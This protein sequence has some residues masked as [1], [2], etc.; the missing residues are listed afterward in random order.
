MP[1]ASSS[2]KSAQA[3]NV[4]PFPTNTIVAAPY[5]V[6]SD[7]EGYSTFQVVDYDDSEGVFYLRDPHDKEQPIITLPGSFLM[8]LS[9][10]IDVEVGDLVMAQ[11]YLE[12]EKVYTTALY[13]GICKSF[14]SETTARVEFFPTHE[15]ESTTEKQE[16][17]FNRMIACPTANILFLKRA[18]RLEY[19]E[20]EI[21]MDTILMDTIVNRG[22]E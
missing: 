20:Y 18:K 8:P 15:H 3:S 7:I 4:Q 17:P 14:P 9:W 12:D 11:Y 5:F 19:A 13:R 6:G 22:S 16:V 2:K 10:E 1:K 21:G